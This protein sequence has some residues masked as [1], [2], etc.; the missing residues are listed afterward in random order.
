MIKYICDKCRKEY[1]TF[2][3]QQCVFPHYKI[4][5]SLSL[6]SIPLSEIN[7]CTD[8]EKKFTEWLNKKD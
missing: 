6:S 4:Y 8:C 1:I 3:E 7:L 5:S 2:P